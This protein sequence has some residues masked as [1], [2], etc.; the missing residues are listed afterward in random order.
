MQ[1]LLSL[2][3]ILSLF[4]THAAAD[5][6][7]LTTDPVTDKPLPEKPV[8][9]EHEGRELRFTD[10][11]SL[12]TFKKDPATVLK[13]VDG[14]IIEQQLNAYPLTQCAVSGEPLGSM[15]EPVNLVVQNRL[16]RVCCSGCKKSAAKDFD[17]VKKKLDDAIIEKQL[18]T[19]PLKTCVVS[20]DELGDDAVNHVHGTTLVRLCCNG[21]V[22]TFGKNPQM[23]LEKRA[24]K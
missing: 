18:A 3:L 2:I 19:Y 6:Y 8:I 13:K 22:K 15:G 9:Y 20:G 14:R 1:K 11:T 4:V 7:P 23:Y 16:V 10:E 5:V 24:A 21:C 17:S 12:E